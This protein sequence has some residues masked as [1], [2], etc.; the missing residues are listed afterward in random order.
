M[1]LNSYF[2][3][4]FSSSNCFYSSS[5]SAFFFLATATISLIYLFLS[6]AAFNYSPFFSYANYNSLAK[7][8]LSSSFLIQALVSSSATAYNYRE[9]GSDFSEP[10]CVCLYSCYTLFCVSR[11]KTTLRARPRFSRSSIGIPWL[12][13]LRSLPVLLLFMVWVI[14]DPFGC[15]VLLKSTR[16]SKLFVINLSSD[17]VSL[18]K[19]FCFDFDRNFLS[20][21][22]SI[23]MFREDSFSSDFS[24]LFSTVAIARACDKC[25]V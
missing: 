16:V 1:L 9:G 13:L 24:S 6:S 25:V 12:T 18:T 5:I 14:L 7:L 17:R 23:L 19:R 3:K 11:S 10:S 22:F 2:K 20:Y 15:S 8:F 4:T 21:P